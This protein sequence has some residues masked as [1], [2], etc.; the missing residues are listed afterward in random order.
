MANWYTTLEAI[1]RSRKINGPEYDAQ[2]GRLIEAASRKIDG[3]VKH[4]LIASDRS[5]FIP[6]TETRLY[7][8]PPTR[9]RSATRLWLDRYLL[10]VTT[11]Q[12]EAQNSSPTTI[13]ATDYF[14]EP[15][16][17]KPYDRIEIDLSST[18]S[19]QAGDTPQRSISVV[20]SWG[21][22]DDTRSTGTVASGL[23]SDAADT[24]MV[25]S[26]ASLINV[27]DTLLVESEQVFVSARD[28]AALGSVLVNDAAITADAADNTITLDGSHGVVAGEVMRLETEE[29]F[30]EY[31]STNLLTVIRAYNG[32]VLAAHANDTA[33]HIN[34]TLTIE[35]AVNGTT[36]ATHANSTAVSKHL[37]PADIIELCTAET[38][39][40]FH[41]EN[42][43]YSRT[44]GPVDSPQEF[45][46][47][48]LAALRNACLGRYRRYSNA[49][50]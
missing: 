42:A 13:A 40:A 37:V 21:W 20:G 44:I 26:N 31:V 34:R 33:V 7:R 1:K 12:S 17:A 28:F 10:S 38:V 4:G 9:M 25:C 39:A 2:I 48:A 29:L 23:S 43:G 27:G 41:Q 6:S 35:R 30:V 46:G 32:S 19:F 14:T 15:N 49:A 8:W 11:L 18:A 5:A 24:S 3:E 45:T 36:G 47:K 22:T 50:V 16:N